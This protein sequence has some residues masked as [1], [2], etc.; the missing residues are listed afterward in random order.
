MTPRCQHT[1]QVGQ[2][3]H[4]CARPGTVVTVIRQERSF[5]VVTCAAHAARARA[6]ARLAT[7]EDGTTDD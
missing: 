4:H 6:F 7:T 2:T 3:W 5:I 1:E